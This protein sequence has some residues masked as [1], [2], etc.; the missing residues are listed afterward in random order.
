MKSLLGYFGA[1]AFA[2][3]AA[4]RAVA[5]G[6]CQ[7]AVGAGES[8]P[9]HHTPRCVSLVWPVGSSA[10]WVDPRVVFFGVV[11]A[12]VGRCRLTPSNPR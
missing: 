8:A 5:S 12:V 2:S 3:A 10:L 7:G 11:A 6:G 1:V 9:V 4:L